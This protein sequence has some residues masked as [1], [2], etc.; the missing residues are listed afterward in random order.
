[1]NQLIGSFLDTQVGQLKLVASD[2]ALV[3]ILWEDED[4]NRVPLSEVTWN[5]TSPIL[6]ETKK[7]LTE[8]FNLERKQ[9]NLPLHIYEGSLS[10]RVWKALSDIPYGETR[11][12]SELAETIGSPKAYRAVGLAN[13]KNPLSIV[14]P[15]HRVI[16]KSGKL[17]G[18]AGG[19][20]VKQAL[21]RMERMEITS[22]GVAYTEDAFAPIE[23][24]GEL[25]LWGLA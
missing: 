12:Y 20:S 22:G 16:A 24:E 8:Y 23:T 18:F 19:I 2:T 13:S 5:N 9:F 7:Q 14:V 6:E 17:S 25:R 3:A 15:C 11:S 4:P 10:S 21:L 1:M